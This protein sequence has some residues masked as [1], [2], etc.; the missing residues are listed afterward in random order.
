MRVKIGIVLGLVCSTWG[1]SATLANGQKRQAA[2]A[3]P[4][5]ASSRQMHRLY[6][7]REKLRAAGVKPLTQLKQPM[8]PLPQAAGIEPKLVKARQLRDH[9]RRVAFG[10]APA[11]R[12]F[13]ALRIPGERTLRRLKSGGD[14]W[15]PVGSGIRDADRS[16]HRAGRIRSLAYGYDSAIGHEVLWVGASSGGLWKSIAGPYGSW[17]SMSDRLP[18]SP[19]VG[20]FLV[21]SGDSNRILVGTGD[22]AR[23]PGDGLYRT[24]DG[25]ATWTRAA[26]DPTPEVFF[27]VLADASDRTGDTVLACG[28]R[29]LGSGGIW[30][31]TDFGRSWTRVFDGPVTDLRQDPVS[32]AFWWAAVPGQGILESSDFGRSFHLIGGTGGTGLTFP[33]DRMSITGCD[34]APNY[35]YALVERGGGLGGVFRSADY[36]LTWSLVESADEISWGQAF[37]TAAIGVHPEDPDKLLV[38]LGGLQRTDNATAPHVAWRRNI[39]GGHADYTAFLFHPPTG[40]VTIANDGGTYSYVWATGAVNGELNLGLNCQQVMAPNGYLALAWG[41]LQ[42]VAGLQD[43]GM[44]LVKPG[45]EP[46]IV[47][48][49]GGDGGQASISDDYPQTYYFS[50]G[51]DYNRYSGRES[52]GWSNINGSLG[53]EWAPTVLV[54]PAGRGKIFTN[55]N[56]Y[57]WY[58]PTT[59]GA[60][61]RVNN[62]HPFPAGFRCKQ[63]DLAPDRD[64]WVL[65]ATAWN[66]G[67]LLVIDSESL[68]S[69]SWTDRT[70]PLPAGSGSADALV[71]AEYWASDSR[72][73]FYATSV[74]RPSR[75]FLSE[76][77]GQNWRDVTGDLA[78]AIPDAS[79]WKLLRHPEIRDRLY[80]ATD[81]GLYCST[82]GGTNWVRFMDGLPEVVNVTDVIIAGEPTPPPPTVIGRD[83]TATPGQRVMLPPYRILIGTYGRGFWARP[84]LW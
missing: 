76:D 47:F 7:P 30:R 38:G 84:L 83:G 55:T 63:V 4:T 32:T 10:P 69:A 72:A 40:R 46:A 80:L 75:A 66:S 11:S 60:W 8:P 14:E 54:D 25:G 52:G 50:S 3:P 21:H 74:S 9:W 28:S 73:V 53:T 43:N 49:G 70:P 68:D 36:G 64:R 16:H 19:S 20:A 35:L 51:V 13:Q 5:K 65:Y 78:G 45:R 44:V 48:R 81:V 57:V 61:T 41:G 6:V 56:E 22:Y 34:S 77:R 42:L 58:R 24:S 71:N 33:I 2:Q 79:Y 39:D 37:H 23:Y 17:Q 62:G 12:S 82:N 27:R 26:L 67:R 1:L 59:G 18:G 15:T 29:G 31:S